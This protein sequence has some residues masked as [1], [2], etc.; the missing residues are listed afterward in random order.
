MGSNSSFSRI[1]SEDTFYKAVVALLIGLPVV[2]FITEI[3]SRFNDAVIPSFF[4]PQI[5]SL[6]GIVGTVLTLIYLIDHIVHKKLRIADIFYLTLVFFMVIAAVFSLNPGEYSAGYVFYCENPLHFLA[7]YWLFFAG[8]L[9]DNS[10]YRKNIL[11]VFLAVALFES[12]FAFLQTFDIE[13]SYSLYYHTSRTAYGLTQNSNFY[14]GMCVLLLAGVTGLY[15][16]AGNFTDS[17]VKE[18]A[19]PVAAGFL[20]YTMLG[21]RARLAWIGFAAMVVFYIISFAVMYRRDKD[22][23][24][25][26][27]AL[28]RSLILLGVYLA[29]FLITFFFTDYI[30][31][32]T[33]RSYWEMANGDVDA[34]GSDRIYNWRMGLAQVPEHWLTGVGLDN[35]RYVF[36]S[37]PGYHD[38]MYLQDKAHNEYLHTLV[39]QGVP[40]L[41]NYLALLIFAGSGAVKSIIN[42]TSYKRRAITWT[43]LGMFITYVAQAMFNSSINYVVIYFWLVIGLITPRTVLRSTKNELKS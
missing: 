43:L 27:A 11:L 9:I 16:F 39:T 15:V 6:F 22:K 31:E 23:K 30:R 18:Y 1:I 21:S 29:V 8:T 33:T 25:L 2:E 17:K 4:Q 10:K 7:Y 37:D 28:K 40:A 12:I 32:A 20:F 34:M 38:G 19:L 5:L 24:V 3:I 14:G 41:I 26:K 42:E 35:Y 36:V 13:L